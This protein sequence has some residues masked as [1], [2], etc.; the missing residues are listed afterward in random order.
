VHAQTY[1]VFTPAQVAFT[2]ENAH[3]VV[4]HLYVKRD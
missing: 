1:G 4:A 3:A 2:L